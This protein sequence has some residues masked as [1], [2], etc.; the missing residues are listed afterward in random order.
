MAGAHSEGND[1]RYCHGVAADGHRRR[2]KLRGRAEHLQG[3]GYGNGRAEPQRAEQ[4]ASSYELFLARLHQNSTFMPQN[5][6]MPGMT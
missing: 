5:A 1:R 3:L 2:A 6:V 4:G